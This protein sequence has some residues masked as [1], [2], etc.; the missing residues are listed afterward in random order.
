MHF[1]V[2]SGE[3]MRKWE[4]TAAAYGGCASSSSAMS[5]IGFQCCAEKRQVHSHGEAQTK[6]KAI[7]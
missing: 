5:Q 7:C 2:H 6:L 4:G 3:S 1:R